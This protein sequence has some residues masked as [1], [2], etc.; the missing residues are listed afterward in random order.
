MP[1]FLD[2]ADIGRKLLTVPDRNG[3]PEFRIALDVAELMFGAK[4]RFCSYSEQRF[5]NRLLVRD[6]RSHSLLDGLVNIGRKG[7]GQK[8]FDL[9]IHA[10]KPTRKSSMDNFGNHQPRSGFGA[11]DTPRSGDFPKFGAG[12]PFLPYSFFFCR[13]TLTFAALIIRSPG[14][15][16]N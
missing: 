1:A 10:G 15:A 7:S 12:A 2:P 4:F 5:E 9:H 6:S 16:K 14:S 11:A 8:G 13:N 3:I